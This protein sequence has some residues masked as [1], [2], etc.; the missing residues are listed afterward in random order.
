MKEKLSTRLVPM[1]LYGRQPKLDWHEVIAEVQQ[2]ENDAELGRQVRRLP[3]RI[4]EHESCAQLNVYHTGQWDVC[5]WLDDEPSSDED[6][7]SAT[8][9]EALRKALGGAS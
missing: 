8:P 1:L 6:F 2:L 9:E 7:N 4:G 3:E 5:S